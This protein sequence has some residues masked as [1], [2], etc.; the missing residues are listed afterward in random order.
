M[1]MGTGARLGTAQQAMVGD[2]SLNANVQ[3]V[4]R[5]MTQQGGLGGMRM[6]TAGPGRQVQDATYFVGILRS[7]IGDIMNEIQRMKGELEKGAKDSVVTAQMERKYDNL[8]KEVRSLEGDL[9]DYNLAM[10]KSRT[11]MDASDIVSVYMTVKRRNE[12]VSRELDSIFMERQD[13]ERGSHRLEEQINE[14][15]RAAEARIN[16]LPPA[17]VAEYRQL[18]AENRALGQDAGAMQSALEQLNAE[19]DAAENDL[20]RDRIRDEYAL[21]EK[22]LL[23]MRRERQSLEDE[24]AATRWVAPRRVASDGMSDGNARLAARWWYSEI[25]AL[26]VMGWCHFDDNA[27]TRRDQWAVFFQFLVSGHC[28]VVF[29]GPNCQRTVHDTHAPLLLCRVAGWTHNKPVT[30][31][32]PK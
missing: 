11:S 14:L 12:A 18:V 29:I 8:L 4:N 31:C 30:C 17:Q 2:M 5:P 7:K 19:V 26:H 6:Q 9:A 24:M 28:F 13:R 32:W 10:D 23:L 3:I 16:S 20:R 22:R 1:R 25:A 21:A 27:F 15:Q